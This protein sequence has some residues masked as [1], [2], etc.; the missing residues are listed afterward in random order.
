MTAPDDYA[1]QL[2]AFPMFLGCEMVENTSERVVLKAEVTGTLLNRNGV[3]HGGAALGMADSAGGQLAAANLP[4]GWA[5][6]T[7]E[8]KTNFLRPVRLG[9]VVTITSIPLHVG[10]TTMLLQTTVTRSDGKVAAIVS[11]TQMIF[12]W[13]QK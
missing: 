6:T 2:P 1:A 13:S 11:Q 3:L 8:S 10:K 12:L 9:E 4:P 7:I 5:T